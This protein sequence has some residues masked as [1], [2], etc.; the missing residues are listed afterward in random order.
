MKPES[1]DFITLNA[2]APVTAEELRQTTDVA[3]LLEKQKWSLQ[4]NFKPAAAGDAAST[5]KTKGA[6]GGPT[7]VS[8]TNDA[9]ARGNTADASET[10]KPA[11]LLVIRP[12]GEAP[13]NW[14]FLALAFL[15]L[16]ALAIKAWI[17]ETILQV[18]DS[19]DFR[20]ALLRWQ[21]KIYVDHK[22][23]RAAKRL[24]NKL[25]LYA[26]L[27]RSFNESRRTEPL[28]ESTLVTFGV[29]EKDGSASS[30]L[31]TTSA[32]ISALTPE[33]RA[34]TDQLLVAVSRHPETF[35]LLHH[36]ID[37]PGENT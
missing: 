18:E 9:S 7:A 13:P 14:L 29:L 37:V 19:D 5:A 26:M 15:G 25:R 17:E 24:I 35:A 20:Q 30:F 6:D 22:T 34:D 31:E 8:S 3:A 16:G 2:V 12:G 11:V 21:D 33:Q 28:A 10:Q 27:T 4:L 36:N 1:F 23:P 32:Q